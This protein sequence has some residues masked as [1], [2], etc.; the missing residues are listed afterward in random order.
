MTAW[1]PTDFPPCGPGH[2]AAGWFAPTRGAR[3]GAG[4]L[5]PG[6]DRTW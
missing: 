1:T 3:K 6:V 4:T 2:D 5:A